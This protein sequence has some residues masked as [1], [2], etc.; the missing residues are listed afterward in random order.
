MSAYTA[1][2]NIDML[3]EAAFAAEVLIDTTLMHCSYR[4]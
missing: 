2:M 4:T 1:Y 3:T